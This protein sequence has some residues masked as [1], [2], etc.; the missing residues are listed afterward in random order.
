MPRDIDFRQITRYCP[1]LDKYVAE[2]R[3]V[4]ETVYQNYF[5]AEVQAHAAVVAAHVNPRT[6]LAG[7]GGRR[8]RIEVRDRDQRLLRQWCIGW[9]GVDSLRPD[10]QCHERRHRVAAGAWGDDG[11]AERLAVEPQTPLEADGV[12]IEE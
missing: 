2:V 6:A 11:V 1:Q 10:G 3:Y 4:S 7:D 9:H 5:D 12:L 8:T